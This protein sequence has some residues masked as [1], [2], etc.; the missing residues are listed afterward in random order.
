LTRKPRRK[1]R[2]RKEGELEPDLERALNNPKIKDA[3]AAQISETETARQNHLAGVTAA[4]QIAQA[5]FMSQFPEFANIPEAQRGQA[6]LAMQQQDP[7]RYAQIETAV[8]RSSEL[9][10]QQGIAQQQE[11]QAKQASLQ[12]YAKTQSESFERMPGVKG[13]SR[14]ERDAIESGIVAKIKEYG[15]DPDQFVKL[16]KGSEFANATVQRLLWDV[17]RLHR[18][19]SAPK[20]VATRGLPQVQRPGIARSRA[21]VDG[22]NLQAMYRQLD[23]AGSEGQQLKIARRILGA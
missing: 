20:A 19:E 12:S 10:R 3:I 5:A 1:R 6:L 11:E 22:E 17:G 13:V 14:S 7:A 15:G 8:M 16:M 21:E 18:I 4:T 2:S 9:F 23:S